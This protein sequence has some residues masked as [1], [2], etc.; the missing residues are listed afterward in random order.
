M[1]SLLLPVA[2]VAGLPGLSAQVIHYVDLGNGPS[3]S[4]A[5]N[6]LNWPLRFNDG[7]ANQTGLNLIEFGSGATSAITITTD[8]FDGYDATNG[9]NLSGTGD[10]AT[11]L[12]PVNFF[13]SISVAQGDGVRKVATI[14]FNN[15]NPLSTYEITLSGDRNN[16]ST[17]TSIFT[18][19]GADTFTNA[20]SAGTFLGAS[21]AETKLITGDNSAGLVARFIGITA[22][23]GSFT[24]EL[25]SDNNRAYVNGLSLVTVST[26]P[27]PAAAVGLVGLV[28]LGMGVCRRRPRR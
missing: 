22:A 28:A 13:G 8:G 24:I 26:I 4:S 20:S 17:R 9:R 27:E 12:A 5:G 19:V 18:I 1:K 25:H 2:L 16:G 23:D 11:Y 15:L 6:V 21:S 3:G 14:T 10:I 7:T